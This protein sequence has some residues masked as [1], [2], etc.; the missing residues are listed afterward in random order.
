M[1][2]LL[3]ATLALLLSAEAR[4]DGGLSPQRQ[5]EI[6][7]EALRA[8]DQAV[9][10]SR[11]DP[12]RAE[13][14]YREASGGFRALIDA[15][16]R[17]AAL[18]YNLG[19]VHFRLGELGRAIVHYRRAERLAPGDVRL[20]RNLRYAR[21]RVEPVITPAGES[22]LTRQLFFWHFNTSP[23]QRFVA[24]VLFQVVAY[25][26]LVAWIWTKRRSLAWVGIVA[27]L[28]GGVVAGS[29]W[30]QL[31]QE[32][33]YPDAVVVDGSIQLRLGRG[34]NADP[35]LK[36]PLGRGVEVQIRQR[37]DRWVRVELRD[38]TT[39]WLPADAI[40]PVQGV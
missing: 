28:L 3:V 6:L 18:E 9:A 38:G 29:L 35:A 30:H 24:L 27:A 33:R 15:G 21:D 40:E 34:E 39:G 36:Q 25:G 5:Q 31:R 17:N 16:I 19:N 4:A 22:L 32:S 11:S 1:G 20:A 37:L 12:Q 2:L 26:C 14:L 7:H 8:Y 10:A 13:D 23:A